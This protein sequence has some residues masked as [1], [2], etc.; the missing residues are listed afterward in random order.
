MTAETPTPSEITA[1]RV[2]AG[3]DK[4][5]AA[6]LIYKSLRTW[7][8]YEAGDRRMDPAFWELFCLKLKE[9]NYL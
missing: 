6:S 3:I 9:K 1:L 2:K 5:V 7:Q 4:P 8:Q